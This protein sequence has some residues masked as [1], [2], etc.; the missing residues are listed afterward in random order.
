MNVIIREYLASL[1]ERGELDVMIPDL[2]SQMGLEV[3]SKPG[4]GGRQYGVDVAAYGSIDD[5]SPKVYLFSIKGGDLDR[6]DWNSGSPQDLRPSLDEILDVYIPTHMP[7][8]YRSKPV[9]IC[10]CFGGDLKETVRLNISQYEDKNTS[11][12]IT[13][14]EWGGER[15]SRLIDDYLL[16]EE[17]LPDEFRSLFRKSLAFLDQ[18]DIAYKNF[19][20]LLKVIISDETK[21]KKDA[22]TKV[23]QLHLCLW[24][25]FAWS[26][27]ENNLES[28]YQAAE[29]TL[30][31]TWEICKPFLGKTNKLAVSV[32][33]TFLHVQNLYMIINIEFME[34]VVIPYANK[35]YAL[36]NAIRS[37][38]LVDINLKLF[39]ILSRTAM[40]GIWLQWNKQMFK[41]L[42]LNL[43]LN[44]EIDKYTK[45]IKELINNNPML[46]SPYKDEHSI[47]ICITAWFLGVS[48][49]NHEFIKQWFSALVQFCRFNFDIHGR[50]PCILK[51]YS[52]L[53]EHPLAK[54]NEYREKV[55]AG[56]VLY[57]MIA[58]FS[59]VFGFD[60]VYKEIQDFQKESLRHCNFQLWY[61]DDS[62]ES[63]FYTNKD[64]HGMTL[65]PI[66]INQ[67]I[68]DFLDQVL[69]ECHATSYFKDMSP[70]HHGMWPL[71]LLGCRHY[72]LPVPMHFLESF[73]DDENSNNECTQ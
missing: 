29:L 46:L 64:I 37:T 70:N 72:R 5:S 31:N 66:H 35:R 43:N 48:S 16:R 45:V 11:D 71:I 8:E 44:I 6:K 42:N 9:E 30:L 28:A 49:P 50:Y 32:K 19:S 61:P 4:I 54:T 25:I 17:L 62:S 59:A 12:G 13:F 58:A 33:S 22:T 63:F 21:G 69:N 53:I 55:T 27:K 23:R 67:K 14:S 39:D 1:K 60:E 20:K 36:S 34:K 7:A 26:R 18:P 65:H 51:S 24:V 52:E 73:I 2:L 56:S 47:D 3:F 41:K 57:P 40:C 68:E 38:C 15:L 10:I